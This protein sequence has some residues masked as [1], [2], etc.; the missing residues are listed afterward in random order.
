MPKQKTKGA[1]KKRFTIT[2]TGKIKRRRAMHSH[3]L[4]KKRPDRKKRLDSSALVAAPDRKR[5]RR[6]LPGS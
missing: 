4:T 5:I 3:I 6:I 2:A 1:V